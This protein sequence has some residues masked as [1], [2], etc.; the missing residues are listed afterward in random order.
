M[1]QIIEDIEKNNKKKISLQMFE[2]EILL[3]FIVVSVKEKKHVFNDFK[4]LL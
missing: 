1:S 4:A 3:L 2:L